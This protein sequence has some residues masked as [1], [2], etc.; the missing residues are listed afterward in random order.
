MEGG[1]GGAGKQRAPRA[2]DCRIHF[3]PGR[4]LHEDTCG[5]WPLHELWGEKERERRCF[6]LVTVEMMAVLCV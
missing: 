1:E 3:K 4:F 5:G 6:A 2:T